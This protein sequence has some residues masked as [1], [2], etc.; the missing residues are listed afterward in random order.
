M[1]RVNKR[2]IAKED[3]PTIQDVVR[4]INVVSLIQQ[5]GVELTAAGSVL[6]GFCPFHKDV[7]TPSLVVYPA[8]NSWTCFGSGCGGRM[9]GRLNGGSVIDWVIQWKRVDF[10]EALDWLAGET[11]RP[12]YVRHE[13]KTPFPKTP[14]SLYMRLVSLSLQGPWFPAATLRQSNEFLFG[15]QHPLAYL[16]LYKQT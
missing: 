4:S 2:R 11:K 1:K 12:Q 9:T 8:T 13:L 14:P 15:L 16:P 6:K 10:R 3:A 5:S 7:D